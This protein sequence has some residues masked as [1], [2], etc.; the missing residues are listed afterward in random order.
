MA[1][2][3]EEFFFQLFL[4]EFIKGIF[5]VVAVNEHG[6]VPLFH[7]EQNDDTVPV[8]SHTQLHLVIYLICHLIYAA[9]SV[10]RV[11]I[12]KGKID[13]TVMVLRISPGP[14]LQLPP[15]LV[16]KQVADVKYIFHF[17]A[18]LPLR[19]CLFPVDRLAVSL[20]RTV[21][22]YVSL[23]RLSHGVHS[24][25][26]RHAA[27][28]HVLAIPRPLRHIGL[29]RIVDGSSQ[30]LAAASPLAEIGID[31][32]AVTGRHGITAPLLRLQQQS[33]SGALFIHAIAVIVPGINA[34]GSVAHAV[35]AGLG[36]YIHTQVEPQCVREL[37]QRLF[38]LH[39]KST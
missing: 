20:R 22:K 25:G 8:I 24:L 31:A 6:I 28:G 21:F 13:T 37:R 33:E 19:R 7:A 29:H 34:C 35:I 30:L 3:S 4:P 36:K 10:V 32:P 39:S 2:I 26:Q 9:V 1:K 23:S 16:A 5:G 38:A 17:Y 11:V 18:V 27:Q 14:R 15:F 12:H